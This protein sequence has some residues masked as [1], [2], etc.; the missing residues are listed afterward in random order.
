M[1]PVENCWTARRIPTRSIVR[2]LAVLAIVVIFLVPSNLAFG[3]GS[4][5][6]P[7]ARSGGVAPSP[8]AAS[9]LTVAAASLSG[10]HYGGA[11]KAP[12]ARPAVGGVNP[13]SWTDITSVAGAGPSGRWLSA[14]TYDPEDNYVV[15]FG[16]YGSSG[17]DSDTWTFANGQWALSSSSGPAGRYAATFVWDPADHEGVLFGGYSGTGIYYNDT[18]TYTHGNWANISGSTNQTPG[19]RWRASMAYDAG[20]GYVVMFGGTNALSVTYSDTWEFKGGFWTKLNVTGSPPGRF[21]ASMAYDPVDNYTVLFGGCTSTCPDS[22]T[23]KY[24]NLTWAALAPTS[25]PAARVYYGITYSPIAKTLLLFGGSSSSASNVPLADT[26]NFTNASWTSLTT[27][28]AHSPTAVAYLEMTFDAGDGYV[29]MFGGQWAN[30][31]YSNRTYVLGPSILGK[32]SASPSAI[33]LGQSTNINATPIAYASY[34]SYN[35]TSLPTGCS[36]GNVSTVA[37]TP[38]TTG[39]FPVVVK[40]NDSSGSPVFENTTVVVSADPGITQYSVNYPNVTVGSAATLRTVATGGTGTYSYHYA[41]LPTG[42]GTVNTANLTCVPTTAGVFTVQVTVTDTAAFH[43]YDNLSVTVNPKP[44]VTSIVALPT[45]LDVGQSV[46][47]RATLT[48][49]TD[50]ITYF[51]SGLPAGCATTNSSTLTCAPS[52]IYNSLVV[53][54]ATDRFGWYSAASVPLVVNADPTFASTAASPGAFDVGTLVHLWANATGGTGT[55]T[56]QYLNLPAGCTPS[57]T[58]ATSCTPQVAGSFSVTAQVTDNVGFIVNATLSFTVN[59]AETLNAVTMTPGTIDVGGTVMI[60][61]TPSGGTAPFTYTYRGLPA[62]CAASTIDG[63]LACSPRTPASYQVS[64]SVKDAS[65]VL[66]TSAGTMVV[67]PDPTLSSF[68]ATANPATIGDTFQIQANAT[69]GTKPY[70]FTYSGLPT[71]CVS[72]NQS[73]LSCTATGTGH[74]VVHV[75]VKDVLGVS[76]SGDTYVNV[77]SKASTSVLGLAPLELYGALAVLAI[78]VVAAIAFLLM[79]RKPPAAKPAKAAPEAWTEEEST[80][81][82]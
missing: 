4:A 72:A 44:N 13:K 65:G 34:V 29:L 32:V 60:N 37:C 55:L 42:C 38:T 23:W 18:W 73:S 11:A 16:G 40:L 57:N 70:T 81:N 77:T 64:V 58:S 25:H 8:H 19:A 71:G 7:T 33:D 21:R 82:P 2:L 74:F 63:T 50:P 15:L 49:G 76:V 26:W 24:Q 28:L 54:N 69:N 43:V 62:G 75:V 68:Q 79:R 12:L 22:T 47:I 48:G 10:G 39:T 45:A 59:P 41:G 1:G 27:S 52:A 56:Y 20:D 80:S 67:H 61:A 17:V 30:L 5:A 9:P 35:Y 53:V 6:V 31:S 46:T 78:V 36:A 66:V 3:R 51:Y 14:M